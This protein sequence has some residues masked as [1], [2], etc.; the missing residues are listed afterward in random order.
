MTDPLAPS[1]VNFLHVSPALAKVRLIVAAG[2]TL[3]PA[4]VFGVLGA[5]SN[6]WFFIPAGVALAVFIWLLWLIPRQ[7]RAIMFATSENDFLVR[8]G[9]MFRSLDVVPY[10]RIQYVDVKEGP[11]ARNLGIATVQLYTAS[12]QTDASLHGLPAAEAAKL[13]DLLVNSGST[14][15]SGF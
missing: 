11:I 3:V 8:R 4:L 1:G 9:I 6:R 5:V 2:F 14:N 15:L 12:A 10:G 13:R 7:V